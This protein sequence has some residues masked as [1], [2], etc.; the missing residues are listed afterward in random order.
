M[1]SKTSRSELGKGWCELWVETVDL[2]PDFQ[3]TL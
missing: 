3:L 1:R 2:I